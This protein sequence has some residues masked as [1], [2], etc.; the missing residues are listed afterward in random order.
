MLEQATEKKNRTISEQNFIKP[1]YEERFYSYSVATPLIDDG[2][3]TNFLELNYPRFLSS[4][5]ALSRSALH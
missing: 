3:G 1:L 2:F 5:K 4:L